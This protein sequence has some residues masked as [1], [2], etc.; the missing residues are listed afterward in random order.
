MRS[1]TWLKK[2]LHD[3][4]ARKNQGQ[5]S[6]ESEMLE[7]LEHHERMIIKQN[8]MIEIAKDLLGGAGGSYM[9]FYRMKVDRLDK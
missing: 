8:K 9:R 6:V 2:Q 4:I 7:A 5:F 3:D 1:T